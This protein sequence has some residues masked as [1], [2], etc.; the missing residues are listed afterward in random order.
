MNVD[1]LRSEVRQYVVARF[2]VP[3]DDPHF[4]D[5]VNLFDFGYIDSFGALELMTFVAERFS[6]EVEAGDW[7]SQNLNSID[8]LAQFVLAKQRSA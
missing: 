6:L 8:S 7:E 4:S 1:D 5:S 2:Q 3:Q